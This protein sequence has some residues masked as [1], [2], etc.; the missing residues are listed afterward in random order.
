MAG[1]MFLVQ[2]IIRG[3]WFCTAIGSGVSLRLASAREL[4]PVPDQ[5][6]LC[7]EGRMPFNTPVRTEEMV[8]TTVVDFRKSLGEP[9]PF[10]CISMF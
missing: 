10:A 7:D 1:L 4:R 2:L 3:F 5:T 9:Y 6:Y 8:L